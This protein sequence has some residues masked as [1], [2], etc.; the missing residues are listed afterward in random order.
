MKTIIFVSTG[1]CGT[2][3]LY[4]LLQSKHLDAV[5]KHQMPFSRLA[6]VVGHF[7]FAF[8]EYEYLKEKLY[9][10][11][12]A[13]FLYKK[14]F[15]STDPLTAMVIPQK[16]INDPDTMIVHISR[17]E[18]EVA[19]SF[20]KISRKR[21]KSLIAH[22]LIPFWQIGIM[23]LENLLNRKIID[24]YKHVCELKNYFFYKKY[25]LNPNY[26]HVTMEDIFYSNALSN[27]LKTF[28]E[29]NVVFTNQEMYKKSNSYME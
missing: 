21:V 20:F 19:Q 24:K 14:S 1:R 6:N 25:S 4:E 9:Q 11:I 26:K 23:P 2:K 17:A 29:E 10:F 12:I 16:I 3:R 7:M 5:V 18:V 13:R 22:N 8:K 28:L 15:I 27:I